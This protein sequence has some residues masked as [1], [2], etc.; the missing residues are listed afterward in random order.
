ML[1]DDQLRMIE[2]AWRL[3]IEAQDCQRALAGAAVGTPSVC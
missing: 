2:E 3:A 1:F